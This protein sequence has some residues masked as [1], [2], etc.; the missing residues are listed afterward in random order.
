MLNNPTLTDTITEHCTQSIKRALAAE[1]HPL[2]ALNCS[3]LTDNDVVR[4]GLIRCLSAVDS[5]RHFLQITDDTYQERIPHSS[6]FNSLKSARRASMLK[7]VE[8]QSYQLH[9]DTLLAQGVDYLSAFPELNE[10]LV[11]AADGHFMDHACHT[12]KSNNGIAYSA[13][14]IYALNLRNGLLS[15]LCTVTNGTRRSQEI[16]I[17]RAQLEKNNK[18]KPPGQQQLY[19]YDK[20]VTDYA[21]W[22]KQKAHQNYMISVAKENA[23][24]TRVEATPFDQTN[25]I[26]VGVEGYDQYETDKGIR[27]NQVT[28]RDPETLHCYRFISTLPASINP[29]TIAILYYK[30]WTIEKAFNNSKSNL[31]ETKAWSSNTH[32][33]NNQM[34]FTAMAYNLLRV[35]E[36]ITKQQDPEWIHPAEKKYTKAL[37]K[38]HAAAQKEG[39]FVN[40]LLFQPRLAR[41]SSYTIRAAQSAII[42]G[43]RCISFMKNLADQL[44]PRGKPVREH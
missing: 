3:T 14:F 15:P 13:G 34:R 27:F 43:K 40:P 5:G 41:I 44:V 36:E 20:A 6:Y 39:C 29:G 10:Y 17:L 2:W 21:W 23:S 31:K 9:C 37:E 7:A 35:F 33:L 18:Q 25:A 32:A 16:P 1:R 28:Y 24:A 19:V 30:R 42:T 12:Q 11:E 4:L 22:D 38:R 26:N 8:Q